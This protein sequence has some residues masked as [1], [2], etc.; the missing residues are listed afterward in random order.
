[1]FATY[2]NEGSATHQRI[3]GAEIFAET[4][5]SV[6]GG[7]VR[8]LIQALYAPGIMDNTI[9][10][11]MAVDYSNI[12]ENNK[13][14]LEKNWSCINVQHNHILIKY[15]K[16][17]NKILKNENKTNSIWYRSIKKKLFIKL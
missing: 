5:G 9:K 6:A 1:M 3:A 11:G 8:P 14:E 2:Y 13:I 12:K 4:G 16:Q 7:A 10:S 17:L 15:K